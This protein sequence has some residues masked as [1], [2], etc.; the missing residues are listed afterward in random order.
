MASNRFL[1]A[2]GV[3]ATRNFVDQSANT[4]LTLLTQEVNKLKIKVTAD[5]ETIANHTTKIE[6]MEPLLNVIDETVDDH[7]V[8]IGV[9]E[10]KV[11][12]NQNRFTTIE[13]NITNIENNME[14]NITNIET[15]I[16]NNSNNISTLETNVNSINTTLTS[17]NSSK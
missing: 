6:T 4:D 5:E 12:S 14:T 16:N 15:S 1:N 17:S 3:Y 11:D 10:A 7:A 8:R 2:G 13:T 9:L